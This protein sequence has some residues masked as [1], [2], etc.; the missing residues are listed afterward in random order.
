MFSLFSSSSIVHPRHHHLH[1]H[2][3]TRSNFDQ[4]CVVFW[5][6]HP[7]LLHIPFATMTVHGS[8]LTA[9]SVHTAGAALQSQIKMYVPQIKKNIEGCKEKVAGLM[10]PAVDEIVALCINADQTYK[11]NFLGRRCGIH[12]ENRARTGVDP[13]NAQ[14]FGIEHLT[15]KLLR[16]QTRKSHGFQKGR[17]GSGCISPAKLHDKELRHVQRLSSEYSFP[18]CG[19]PPGYM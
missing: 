1:L 6:A 15:A 10:Q 18:R 4:A 5:I 11:K 7:F 17:T 14:K 16:V 12:P 2:I 8:S 9:A 19:I 13:F 3:C